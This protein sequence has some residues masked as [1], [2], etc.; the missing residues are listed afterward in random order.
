[1]P[2]SIIIYRG[3]YFGLY[4]NLILK[5]QYLGINKMVAELIL[6]PFASSIGGLIFSL[7]FNQLRKFKMSQ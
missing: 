3:I 2:L 5:K 1:V 4:D 7:P 6:F